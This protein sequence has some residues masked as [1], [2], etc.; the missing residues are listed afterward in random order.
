M[1]VDTLPGQCTG[2][3]L[4]IG[5]GYRVTV[6]DVTSAAFKTDIFAFR[7]FIVLNL[8]TS[9][10]SNY[11]LCTNMTQILHRLFRQ[12]ASYYAC[13]CSKNFLLRNPRVCTTSSQQRI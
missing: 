5:T 9:L 7:F 4:F 10:Q 13:T 11:P 6:R 3:E 8:S 12:T 1:T 2:P